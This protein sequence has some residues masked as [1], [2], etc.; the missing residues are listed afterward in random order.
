MFKSSQPVDVFLPSYFAR[1]PI[2]AMVIGST[3]AAAM[4]H[5]EFR[6]F[7]ALCRF[8]GAARIVNPTRATLMKMTGMT[9][10]NIS[11]AT[12][13]LQDKRWL[14]IHYENGDKRRKV[15]NYELRLASEEFVHDRADLHEAE[16]EDDYLCREPDVNALTEDELEEL[17]NLGGR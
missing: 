13:A 8:R 2:E 14:T 7:V 6:V 12:R 17:I 9:P 4:S 5:A 3:G 11:R 16:D 1:V 10:N 15:T